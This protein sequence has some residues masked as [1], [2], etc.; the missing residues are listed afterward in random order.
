MD[1]A[2]IL[3]F[4]V[5]VG[6]AM[7]TPGP[8]MVA[9]VARVLASGRR[10]NVVF[11]VGLIVG[12]VVWLAAAVFG[13]AAIATWLHEVI[14]VLKWAGAAYLVYLAWRLW[15]APV[16]LPDAAARPV[17]RFWREAVGGL[18]LALSNPKTMMFYLALL[19]NLID[20]GAIDAVTFAELVVVMSVVYSAV[21]SGYILCADR[22][23]R[24]FV[25][26]TVMRAVNRGCAALM[27]GAAA[28]VA[29]R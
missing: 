20:V 12:D 1:F 26:R 27:A 29:S 7:A 19:P 10:G 15:T 16:T 18:T 5:V 11:G 3:F 4:A 24:W 14:A 28:A 22:A 17:S 21:L 13:V 25:S 6:I 2:S 23:R 9:L 8:T